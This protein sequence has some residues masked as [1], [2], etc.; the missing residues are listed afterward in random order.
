MKLVMQHL[1]KPEHLGATCARDVMGA[2]VGGV[3]DLRGLDDEVAA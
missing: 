2:V 1:G 3:I